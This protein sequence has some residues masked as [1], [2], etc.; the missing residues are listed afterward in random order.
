MGSAQLSQGELTSAG[1]VSLLM[2]A[3]LLTQPVS[4]LA[5]VYGQ[6]QRTRGSADRIFE[7]KDGRF[8]TSQKSGAGG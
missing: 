2:Y 4:G 6:L 1:L 8:V 5:D 7:L 3:M